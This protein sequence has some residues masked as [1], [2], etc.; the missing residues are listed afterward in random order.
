MFPHGLE[1]AA[2]TDRSE[3]PHLAY[4]N[5]PLLPAHA[6]DS[7]E[8]LKTE[9]QATVSDPPAEIRELIEAFRPRT[10]APADWARVREFVTAAM[11]AVVPLNRHTFYQLS[12]AVVSLT[13]WA[14]LER[15][16]PLKYRLLLSAEVVTKWQEHESR[17]RGLSAGTVRNYRGHIARVA[18]VLGVEPDPQF[19]PI[20]RVARAIPYSAQ[21]LEAI[22]LWTRTL[23]PRSRHR[24]GGPRDS[25]R[26]DP[27][28]RAGPPR[29]GPAACAGPAGQSE[30]CL[31]D[32]AHLP[33]L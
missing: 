14:H 26:A 21:E 12:A 9:L 27:R 33:R 3:R 4:G 25:P 29:A 1:P 2:A 32:R 6:A 7:P 20:H 13:S 24:D 31:P 17:T 10:M 23:T 11:L 8:A 28:G 5:H 15:G 19:G 30:P 18:H 22:W 16:L